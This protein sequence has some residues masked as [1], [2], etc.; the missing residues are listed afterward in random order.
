MMAPRRSLSL[1]SLGVLLAGAT[2]APSVDEAHQKPIA[3]RIRESAS[4]ARQGAL[5]EARL[6]IASVL[7]AAPKEPGALMVQACVLLE[8]GA[9]DAAAQ[10]VARLR[11]V[12]PEQAEGRVLEALV[13]LR[14]A[15]PAGEWREAFIA[16]WIE[17]GR[18]D[19]GVESLLPEGTPGWGPEA[20]RAVWRGTQAPDTRLLAALMVGPSQE[21]QRWIASHLSEVADPDLLRATLETFH[22]EVMD[23]TARRQ[24][25]A[26]LRE[27]LTP[28]A[29]ESRESQLPLLMLLEHTAQEAPLTEEELQALERIAALPRYRTT[30]FARLYSDAERRMKVAGIQAPVDGAFMAAVGELALV[31]P[32]VLFNRAKAS[33]ELPEEERIRLGR[34]LWTLGERIAEGNT[35]VERLVGLR[36]MEQGARL[37]PGFDVKRAAVT[38]D[39]ARGRAMAAASNQIHLDVWPLP[40]LHRDWLKASLDNE[41]KHLSALVAP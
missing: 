10:T 40:S 19:F 4:Q 27:R 24:I 38:A 31:G 2:P 26:S 23:E 8:Q 14:R 7:K 15:N 13:R 41:W 34:A 22:S 35:L 36:Q 17:A 9:L 20:I 11:E 32:M 1:L 29:A 30:S 5:S 33:T 25:Q 39:L 37:L 6:E 28:L 21:Q 3:D 18:P 16:A 12:A